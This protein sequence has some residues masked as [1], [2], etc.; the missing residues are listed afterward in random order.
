VESTAATLAELVKGR[1]V[2]PADL[3]INTAAAIEQAQP[4]SVTFLA[5]PKYFALFEKTRAS[6][7]IVPEDFHLPSEKPV[8]RCKNPYY[9]FAI[10]MQQLYPLE[11][12]L[13]V[14]VHP[15]AIIGEGSTIAEK[16]AIGPYVVIGKG[17][18]IGENTALYPF[19]CVGDEAVIG[20]E[21]II[22]AHVSI[23]EG[24]I[25]G[26]RVI[27]HDNTVIGSDGFGF[28]PEG[29]I[30]HKIP[31]IGTV[32]IEDEVEIGANTTIDRGTMAQ[33]VI[34]KGV[35]LDNLIQIAHNC[36]LGENTVIAAQAG[37]SGSTIVG[38]GVRIGG[39]AGF[40]GHQKIGD[41]AIIGAQAGVSK[42][43]PDRIMVSGTPARPH[44]Q[45]LKITAALQK[46]PQ[47]MQETA[48]LKKR[49]EQL[50]EENKEES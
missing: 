9:A 30:Y 28:A 41:N 34:R 37:L 12:K 3:K 5:N 46:L 39:Q 13:E 24:V 25:I 50:E 17:C 26:N 8:I 45:E 11:H 40:A 23:R 38:N 36:V 44:R 7:I 6:L 2:G 33:T 18:S 21:C 29:G 32:V 1:Y 15:T 47:L 19:T 16:A 20:R 35:K 31:Q 48:A 49:I 22:H 42:S 43:V 4:G 10:I 27:I 14:G